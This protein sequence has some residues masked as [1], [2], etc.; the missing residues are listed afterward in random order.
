MAETPKIEERCRRCGSPV[1]GTAGTQEEAL[2]CGQCRIELAEQ[3]IPDSIGRPKA[4]P[5]RRSMGRRIATI[6]LLVL[7]LAVVAYRLPA[8]IR[9]IEGPRPIR[10]GTSET[11]AK[12][13]DCIRNLWTVAKQLQQSG[14]FDA[15]LLRCPSSGRPYSTEGT[16]EEMKVRC[17]NPEA[18]GLAVL[19]VSRSAPVPEVRP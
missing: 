9:A 10:Q 17:P 3:Q 6:L 12:A 15:G 4:A 11:D 14:A 13:D 2:L 19:S 7:A 16:G 5:P 18:H 8:L 1:A